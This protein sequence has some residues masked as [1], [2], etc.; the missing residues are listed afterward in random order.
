M[1][2]E[3][4]FWS[5]GLFAIHQRMY[6]DHSIP[7]PGCIIDTVPSVGE[8][9]KRYAIRYATMVERALRDD[10]FMVGN[11]LTGA[12]FMLSHPLF[13]ANLENWFADLPK[14]RA[15]VDRFAARP[16]FK[17]AI[18]DTMLELGKFADPSQ[19]FMSFRSFEPEGVWSLSAS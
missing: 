6:W 10:G 5:E 9:G 7:A 8:Y 18:E 14:I 3:W 13:L 19:K 15:Y 4:M 11:E 12:D 17:A 16:A 1:V 2:D